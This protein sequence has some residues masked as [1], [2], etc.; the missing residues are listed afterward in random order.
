MSENAGSSSARHGARHAATG[1]GGARV[2]RRG[3]RSTGGTH[4]AG[5]TTNHYQNYSVG[6]DYDSDGM[7]EQAAPRPVLDPAAT[8]SFQ[9]IDASMGAAATEASAG[10]LARTARRRSA[11][12]P[13]RAPTAS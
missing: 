12:S 6:H 2:P 3:G 13:R 5:A 9:R 4:F 7:A 1:S 10:S 8:G 11:A